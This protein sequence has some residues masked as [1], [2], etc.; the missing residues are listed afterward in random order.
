MIFEKIDKFTDIIYIAIVYWVYNDVEIITLSN[1]IKDLIAK[2]WFARKNK[3]RQT[4]VIL[5]RF[6]NGS[7]PKF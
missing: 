5:V 3:G 7:D 1:Y 2:N 4:C 6:H